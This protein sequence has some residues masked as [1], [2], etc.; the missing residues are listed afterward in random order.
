MC[1]RLRINILVG[2]AF[3]NRLTSWGLKE[4]IGIRPYAS[5]DETYF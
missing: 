2:L 5:V 1:N 3:E 4:L